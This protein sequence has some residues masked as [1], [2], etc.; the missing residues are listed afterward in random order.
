MRIPVEAAGYK[1]EDRAEVRERV[2]RE[3]RP[4]WR[5]GGGGLDYYG[6]GHRSP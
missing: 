2:G 5:G 6:P 1:E 4:E 3:R